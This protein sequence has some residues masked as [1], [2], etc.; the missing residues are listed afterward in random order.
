VIGERGELLLQ[1]VE[2]LHDSDVR[3]VALPHRG[4]PSSWQG[5]S[6]GAMYQRITLGASLRRN[7]DTVYDRVSVELINER[8]AKRSHLPRDDPVLVLMRDKP[9]AHVITRFTDGS[10]RQEL[11]YFIIHWTSELDRIQIERSLLSTRSNLSAMC[12]RHRA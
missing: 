11:G 2:Q 1:L 8:C 9:K 3:A 6:A 5:L 12:A 4:P 7:S 10:F